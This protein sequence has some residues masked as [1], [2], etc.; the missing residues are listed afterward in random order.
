[1]LVFREKL[2]EQILQRAQ[3]GVGVEKVGHLFAD[4]LR[5]IKDRFAGWGHRRRPEP[6]HG[7][8]FAV[9]D[10]VHDVPLLDARICAVV[11]GWVASGVAEC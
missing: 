8:Y 5:P 6:Y 7:G 3:L 1:M 10:G 4:R 9:S 2:V 11:E